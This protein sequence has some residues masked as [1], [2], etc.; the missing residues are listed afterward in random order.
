LAVN[1]RNTYFAVIAL[2]GAFAAV[3]LTE[4]PFWG[5]M[6]QV[7]REDTMAATGALNTG[8]NVG[9]VIGTPIVAALSGQGMWNTAFVVGAGLAVASALLWLGVNA[10][11]PLDVEG[12]KEV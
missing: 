6:M 8:G 10:M 2:S 5:A 7:S 3:E 11:R 4:G 1:A 9:G 12:S